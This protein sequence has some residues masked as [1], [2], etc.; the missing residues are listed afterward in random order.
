MA[1]AALNMTDHI[2]SSLPSLFPLRLGS[3]QNDGRR[4]DAIAQARG[5][6][7]VIKDM[8]EMAAAVGAQN[9]FAMHAVTV[10]DPNDDR[11]QIREIVKAWPAAAGIE[12]CLGSKKDFSTPGAAVNPRRFCFPIGA[13][14]GPFRSSFAQDVKLFGRQLFAPFGIRFGD[15]VFH[16]SIIVFNG[17]VSAG[18]KIRIP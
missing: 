15:R 2:I 5:F 1:R 11:F 18:R 13:G 6:R 14:E 17:P 10:I 12:F 8:A 4:I 9:F 16:Y 7:S 3:F